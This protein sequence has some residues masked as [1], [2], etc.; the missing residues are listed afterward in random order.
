MLLF[1]VTGTSSAICRQATPY[2]GRRKK[3]APN[4]FTKIIKKT[5]D[6]L[7]DRGYN[8]LVIEKGLG[9]ERGKKDDVQRIC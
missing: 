6:I 2:G 8:E 5:I 9:P 1:A 7:K 4:N 3:P